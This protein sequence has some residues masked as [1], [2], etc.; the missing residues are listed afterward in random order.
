VAHTLIYDLVDERRRVILFGT[1]P[2]NIT[3]VSTDMNGALL[4]FNGDRIRHRGSVRYGVNESIFFKLVNLYVDGWSLGSMN[5]SLFLPLSAISSSL[6]MRRTE[7]A[8]VSTVKSTP[9][10]GWKST[11]R[12][13][14]KKR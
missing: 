7:S 12:K 5:R 3:E 11:H 14:K 13:V 1:G 4:F 10:T 9:L 8:R 2:I 6:P